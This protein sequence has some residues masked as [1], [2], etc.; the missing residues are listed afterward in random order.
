MKRVFSLTLILLNFNSAFGQI[1]SPKIDYTI[2][3]HYECDSMVIYEYGSLLQKEWETLDF[4]DSLEEKSPIYKNVIYYSNGTLN[5]QKIYEF[6]NASWVMTSFVNYDVDRTKITQHSTG[7]FFGSEISH[8]EEYDLDYI[9]ITKLAPIEILPA[10]DTG[11]V[12]FDK[13]ALGQYETEMDKIRKGSIASHKVS[14]KEHLRFFTNVDGDTIR[15]E[16]TFFDDDEIDV[17]IETHLRLSRQKKMKYS[18]NGDVLTAGRLSFQYKYNE[19][20]QWVL[21]NLNGNLMKREIY[22]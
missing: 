8:T 9:W 22:P 20:G 17:N 19:K 11:R 1:V 2:N 4:D 15:I 10:E 21:M 7:I 6:D 18:G 3:L 12:L 13:V 5:Q 14:D 16:R